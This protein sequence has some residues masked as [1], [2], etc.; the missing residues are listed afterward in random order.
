MGH[1]LEVYRSV[2][3]HG[4]EAYL[5]AERGGQLVNGAVIPGLLVGAVYGVRSGA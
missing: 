4:A 2:P 1:G 5:D 3:A